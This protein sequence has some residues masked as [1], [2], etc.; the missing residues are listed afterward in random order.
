MWLY[1]FHIF[2]AISIYL[3]SLEIILPQTILSMA[4][5]LLNFPLYYLFVFSFDLGIIGAAWA[6]VISNIAQL[7]S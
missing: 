2:N 4:F 5:I 3:E 1:P 7:A 6:S